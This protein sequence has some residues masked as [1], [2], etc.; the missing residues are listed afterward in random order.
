MEQKTGYSGWNVYDAAIAQMIRRRILTAQGRVQSQ[1][2]QCGICDASNCSV[3]RFS[4]TTFRFPF[5]TVISSVFRVHISPP[6][7]WEIGLTNQSQIIT[8]VLSWGF[9]TSGMVPG[10]KLKNFRV[11][12]VTYQLTWLWNTEE[13]TKLRH[14]RGYIQKF[15]D[16]VDNEIYAYLRYYSLRSNT[17][18]YGGKTNKIAIQLH[19]VAESCT[20]C[21]SRARRPVRK[22]L[23]TPSYLHWRKAVMIW[24]YMRQGVINVTICMPS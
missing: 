21:S 2:S 18:G 9:F 10:L 8:W 7:R 6:L 13:I 16:W 17:K 24:G 3:I 23:D 4:P 19:L 14:L 20:I 5:P 11:K 22:L 12:K 15:M 1:D